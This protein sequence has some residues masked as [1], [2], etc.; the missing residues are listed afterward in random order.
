MYKCK[1]FV[2]TS[3]TTLE[4][5]IN[6]FMDRE[7]VSTIVELQYVPPVYDPDAKKMVFSAMLKYRTVAS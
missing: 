3:Q 5:E 1:L 4:Y 2:S 7:E 6:E